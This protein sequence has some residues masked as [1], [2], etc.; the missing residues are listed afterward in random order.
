MTV[1][2]EALPGATILATGVFYD[3]GKE[4]FGGPILALFGGQPAP[5]AFA[6]FACHMTRLT[7]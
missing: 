1:R 4:G 3:N 6:G 7:R 5:G 2:T